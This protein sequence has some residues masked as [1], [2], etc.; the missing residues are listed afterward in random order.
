M[1]KY[2]FK[3]LYDNLNHDNKISITNGT[4]QQMPLYVR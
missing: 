1:F 2:T 4:T 3:L